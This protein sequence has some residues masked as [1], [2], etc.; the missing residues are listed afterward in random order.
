MTPGPTPGRP[1]LLAASDLVG[2]GGGIEIFDEGIGE[3][4]ATAPQSRRPFAMSTASRCSRVSTMP[5][6]SASVINMSRTTKALLEVL[7]EDMMEEATTPSAAAAAAVIDPFGEAHNSLVRQRLSAL[8]DCDGTMHLHQGAN[9]P[10]VLTAPSSA[11]L[12]ERGAVVELAEAF[13][14]DLDAGGPAAEGESSRVFRGIRVGDT[15]D[16][17]CC[18][19]ALKVSMPPAHGEWLIAQVIKARVAPERQ[20]FFLVHSEAHFYDN[21]SVLVSPFHHSGTLMRAIHAHQ[22]AGRRMEEPLCMYYTIEI[23]RIVSI[24]HSEARVIH[25]DIKPDNLLVMSSSSSSGGGSDDAS[26]T[27]GDWTQTCSRGGWEGRGLVLLDFGHAIDRSMYPPGTLFSGRCHSET[28]TCADMRAGMPWGFQVDTHGIAVTVHCMLFGSWLQAVP[29]AA[30]A[31]PGGST[32]VRWRPKEEFKKYWMHQLWAELFDTLL[33][34]DEDVSLDA[35]RGKFENALKDPRR[36]REVRM[37]LSRQDVLLAEY[38]EE[39][40]E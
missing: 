39:A 31:T 16:L 32:R 21:A 37:L 20:R 30:P 29:Q 9:A 36:A 18:P 14:Y 17:P 24:L 7:D 22:R 19:L 34:A 33:N 15:S 13:K 5:T 8:R 23:L 27:W 10:A 3:A 12:A 25:A 4:A 11:A 40:T 26:A 28:F 1:Q 38:T 6:P 35:L 2:G